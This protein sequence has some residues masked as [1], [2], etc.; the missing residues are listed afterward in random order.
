MSVGQLT[1]IGIADVCGI[2]DNCGIAGL[3]DS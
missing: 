1:F 3:W 2:A